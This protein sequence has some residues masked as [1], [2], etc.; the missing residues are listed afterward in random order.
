MSED[1]STGG[2]CLRLPGRAV[3][4]W[5]RWWCYLVPAVVF[6]AL[7]LPHLDQ[8][9]FRTDTG[10]YAAVGLQMWRTGGFWTPRLQPDVLY[11]SKPPLVFWIHGLSLRA[12]GVGVWQAR[13][14]TV[15]AGLGCVLV[16]V[17]LARR[18]AGRTRALA[19]GVVLATTLEFFR[20]TKEISI[21]MWQALF[22]LGAA[23]CVSVAITR[24]R[25][26]RSDAAWFALAGVGVGLALMCKPLVGLLAVPILAAWMVL[27]GEWRRVGWLG[28]TVAAAAVVAGPWHV[29]MAAVH[30]EAFVGRYFGKEI[31]E[32][33]AGEIVREP[34]WY[35][36]NEMVQYHWPWLIAAAGGLAAWAFAFP[37]GFGR[38]DRRGVALAVVWSVGWLAL[39]SAFPDKRP[40]YGLLFY[41]SLAWVAGV[42][43]VEVLPADWRRFLLRA[44]GVITACVAVGG[45]AFALAPVRV[46]RPA[47]PGFEA[48]AGWMREHPGRT[49]VVGDVGSNEN[50]WVYLLT[51]RWAERVGG[52]RCPEAP[53]DAAYLWVDYHTPKAKVPKGHAVLL[54]VGVA[55]VTEVR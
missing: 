26:A 6:L 22:L 52:E 27:V 45:A 36:F 50:G 40:R 29:C 53:A 30:G 17:A 24:R 4:R 23:W 34:W 35:Y 1:A 46:N 8:G 7:T 14:P 19:V 20:R 11:F 37:R 16:M 33:A 9:G 41:P 42:W 44:L 38:P 55:R 10:R 47:D 18:Y 12:L 5:A 28:L 13:L 31:A 21:D 25:G 48:V 49:V 2:S 39:L 51:G 15:L 54:D 43:V 32:R 3:R